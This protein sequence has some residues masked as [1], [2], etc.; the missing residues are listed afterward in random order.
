MGDEEVKRCS[1]DG[2]WVAGANGERGRRRGTQMRAHRKGL[3]CGGAIEM[4]E[5]GGAREVPLFRL[6]TRTTSLGH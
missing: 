2:D 1:D 3:I 6:R 5:N 4:R